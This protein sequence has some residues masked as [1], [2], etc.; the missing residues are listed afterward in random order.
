MD[1]WCTDCRRSYSRDYYDAHHRKFPR[2]QRP[3]QSKAERQQKNR[4]WY[5]ANK[6]RIRVLTEEKRQAEREKNAA[7]PS[8]WKPYRLARVLKAAKARAKKD[9]LAFDLTLD[10]LL[11]IATENC[12]VDNLPLQWEVKAQKDAGPSPRSPSIDKLIPSLG[13][14]KGN[15]RI[16]CHQYNSWKR[17]MTIG[18]M[19]T[20]LAYLKQNQS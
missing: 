14:T 16:I 1:R 4:G 2:G 17:D 19:R 9:N 8:S 3:R 12:P 13:Y 20:L 10:Y 18:D 7:D 11:S 6:E 15:V 5:E